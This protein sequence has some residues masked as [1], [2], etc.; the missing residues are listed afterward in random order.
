MT[1][2]HRFLTTPPLA[3][4]G[5]R[6]M[7]RHPLSRLAFGLSL[8]VLGGSSASGFDGCTS[9]ADVHCHRAPA[10]NFYFQRHV[11]GPRW[12]YAAAA[13]SPS[14]YDHVGTRPATQG[15]G[16][17]PYPSEVRTNRPSIP[18]SSHTISGWRDHGACSDVCEIPARRPTLSS[19]N[20]PTR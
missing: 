18:A 13:Y 20:V 1:C 5:P 2:I 3:T 12:D 19:I 7:R 8:F 15:R 6:Q 14:A 9:S 4:S 11:L 17:R 10:T 16:G